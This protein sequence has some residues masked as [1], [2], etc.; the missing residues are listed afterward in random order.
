MM[1]CPLELEPR[2]WLFGWIQWSFIQLYFI[3]HAPK[4]GSGTFHLETIDLLDT[5]DYFK[6]DTL[7][8][9]TV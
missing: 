7:S 8:G 3:C 6:G 2:I 9:K 1:P 4:I 5:Q